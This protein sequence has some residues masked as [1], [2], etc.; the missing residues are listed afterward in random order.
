MTQDECCW[1]MSMSLQHRG[2][3]AHVAKRA[4]VRAVYQPEGS[5]EE[6]HFYR[7]YATR[8]QYR[9]PALPPC[10]FPGQHSVHACAGAL[11]QVPPGIDG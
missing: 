2:R 11:G 8:A 4:Y 3:T 9:C 1:L 5:D 10:E 6:I 7:R